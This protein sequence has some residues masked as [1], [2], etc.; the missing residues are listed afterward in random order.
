VKPRALLALLLILSCAQPAPKRAI[1]RRP[2]KPGPYVLPTDTVNERTS[3]LD[4]TRGATIVSRTGEAML[5]TSAIS[6][7]DGQIGTFWTPPPRDYPQSIVVALGARSRIDRVGFRTLTEGGYE[8]NHL[9]FER[10]LDGAA[11]QPLATMTARQIDQAQWL[12]VAPSEAAYLRVTIPDAKSAV[13]DVRLR[14]LL[15]RGT[16][17]GPRSDPPIDGCW[18]INGEA[19]S[20]VQRGSQASGVLAQGAQPVLLAGGTNGRIWR[21]NWI[22]GHDFGFVALAV[23]PDGKHLSALVWHEEAIPLFTAI[24]WFGE[25][26]P[27]AAPARSGDVASAVLQRA[28]HVPMFALQ[29]DAAGE[30]QTEASREELQS[31]ASIIRS[32]PLALRIVA[33]EFRQSDAKHD[34]E[35]A[36]HEIASLHKALANLGTDLSRVEF[37]AAGSDAPRQTPG[38]DAARAIYSS[39]E[40]EVRR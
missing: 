2:Q 7:I 15:A 18:S 20:F 39:V 12:D 4:I 32:A 34:K 3:L 33:H 36:E 37:I 24:P 38:S 14:S 17:I 29:F 9:T 22:R 16:E 23:S 1:A 5:V 19:A 35:I 8:A 6:I 13:H 10:S 30:F 28:E 25:R 26:T 40:V 11:W 31:L 21:F 27:C